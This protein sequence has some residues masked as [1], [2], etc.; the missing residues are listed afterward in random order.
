M[1]QENVVQIISKILNASNL[2]VSDLKKN[3]LSSD[4]LKLL[5]EEELTAF[6]SIDINQIDRFLEGSDA[7][8]EN[9]LCNINHG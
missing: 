8:R 4:Q 6:N 9:S 7:R 1:A 5:S 2:S 3:G